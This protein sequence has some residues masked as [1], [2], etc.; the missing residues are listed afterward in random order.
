MFKWKSAMLLT[1]QK[2]KMAVVK[3]AILLSLDSRLRCMKHFVFLFYYFFLDQ[4]CTW[5]KHYMA[6]RSE[7]M[8]HLKRCQSITIHR[9]CVYPTIINVIRI[10]SIYFQVIALF[11]YQYI[12]NFSK[13]YSANIEFYIYWRFSRGNNCSQRPWMV[14]IQNAFIGIQRRL[15]PPKH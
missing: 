1:S 9:L 13:S 11:H 14:D 2:T 10:W 5:G 6:S 12:S 4:L 15:T 7:N 3:K 8:C